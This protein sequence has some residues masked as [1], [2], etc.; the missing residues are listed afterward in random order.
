MPYADPESRLAF[1]RARYKERYDNERGFRQRES[2]R[3][4]EYYATNETYQRLVKK[5]VKRSRRKKGAA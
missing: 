1:M 5:A 2:R 3:K 4:A